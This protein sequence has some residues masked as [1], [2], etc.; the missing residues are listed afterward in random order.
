MKKLQ[1][2]AYENLVD[3]KGGHGIGMNIHG[4]QPKPRNGHL[5][6]KISSWVIAI[7]RHCYLSTP[8][9]SNLFKTPNFLN[10]PL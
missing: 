10:Y 5:C 2:L 6:T 8:T 4:S 9:F 7:V 3:I 1:D